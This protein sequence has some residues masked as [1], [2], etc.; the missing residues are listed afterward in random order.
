MPRDGDLSPAL[1]SAQVLRRSIALASMQAG[2]SE[3]GSIPEGMSF[4]A[5]CEDLARHGLKVDGK[6][7]SLANRPALVPLYE[8]IPCTV[9]EARRFTL[10]VMKG[11]QLGLTVWEMLADLYLAIKFEPLVIGM[12]LPSQALAG[13][14]SERRF[15][16][17][18]RTVPD[19][20][21]KLTTR[22]E[23]DRVV[24]VGEGN[25][26]T[27]VM[28]E[29]AFL[30]LW[31]SGSTVTE[32]R[33]MDCVSFDEVQEMTLEQIDRT[34]E[35]MSASDFRFTMMLSTANWPDLDIDYWFH[36]GSRERWHT[37]CR[38]CSA[39]S[40]L[41]QHFPKCIE[42]NTGQHPDAEMGEYVYVCPACQAHIPDTQHGRYIADDPTKITRTRSLHISQ[43][44]SPTITARDMIEQWNRAVTGDQKKTFYN[45]KLGLPFVDKD[46]LPVTMEH[47]NAA[48]A[49]GARIGLVWKDKARGPTFM[50]IDQMGSFNVAI[51]KERLPDGR[52]AVIHAE[53]I[54]NDDPFARCTDLMDQFRVAVCVVE[55]LP[56]VNDARRFANA[57][58]HK[59]RVFLAGYSG[60]AKA[61]MI[62]WGDQISRNDQKTSQEDRSRYSVVLQQYKA[63]QTALFRV[64]NLQCLFP[65][66]GDRVQ[67]VIEKGE[68][69]RIPILD[70]LFLH[71]TKTALVVE[72][73]EETRARKPLVKKVGLDP[74]FS[75]ANML[76][77]VAWARQHGTGMVILPENPANAPLSAP[78]AVNAE[79]NMPGLPRQVLQM[80]DQVAPG[81]CGACEAFRDGYCTAREFAVGEKDAACP[82]YVGRE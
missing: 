31:T 64:K 13:D 71:L 2:Y 25:V 49:E 14:K 45:R 48:V 53:A 24:K 16:R 3:P 65:P 50:G 30:F 61:D 19:A 39:E 8:A 57:E 23:G 52:Q 60:D 34:R 37:H 47:C 12:F 79:K 77:D 76:C 66:P 35:R 20:H 43:V 18:L 70:W 7:W 17:L 58:K 67:D 54:F 22:V 72:E 82:F 51:I 36:Q 26:M 42:I 44:T 38:V 46:Q 5:W 81:T 74:H 40:D 56:N 62:V 9:E 28:G 27:R 1:L 63:M 33:P 21:R 4:I 41:T 29:S 78:A 32:S 15:M 55:Q 10:V 69:K 11:A 68:T 73:D 75:Y 80:M 59:G 6:P